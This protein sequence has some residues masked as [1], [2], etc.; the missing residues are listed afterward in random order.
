MYQLNAEFIVILYI[1][2]NN[3]S[4][5]FFVHKYLLIHIL[6]VIDISFSFKIS[7][8]FSNALDESVSMSRND[9]SD[10]NSTCDSNSTSDSDMVIDL[11]IKEYIDKQI[12]K[13][14]SKSSVVKKKIYIY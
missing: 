9:S 8:L 13:K 7:C 1:S 6:P 11:A 5:N 3:S 12:E 10:S 2:E 14:L 4:R